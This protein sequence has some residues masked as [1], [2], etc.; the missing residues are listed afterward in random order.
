MASATGTDTGSAF[1]S[2]GA[3][4]HGIR[5]AFGTIPGARADGRG[6]CIGADAL[7]LAPLKG[8]AGDGY[9]IARSAGKITLHANTAVGVIGGLLALAEPAQAPDELLPRFKTR[10]YKHEIRF[11]SDEGPKKGGAASTVRPITRYTPAFVEAF[12]RELVRRHFNGLVLYAGYHP[13]E[14]FLDYEGFPHATYKPAEER[15]ENFRALKLLYGTA[16]KY[17][18]TTFLHHYVTHFTQA[19]SDHLNLSLKETGTRL[20]SF[21]H[22]RIYEYNRYIYRRT[23]ETLPELDGLYMNFESAAN[24]TAYMEK[25]LIPV[26]NA[27]ARKPVLFFRLWGISDVA[28]MKRLLAQYKGRKGL[29]HKIQENNDTYYYPVADDRVKVWKK[30]IPGIEFTFSVGPCHNCATNVG[31][32]LWT[33]LDYIHDLLASAQ[34]KGADSI[35]FQSTFELLLGHLPDAEFFPEHERNHARMNQGHLGAVVDY[36]RGQRPGPDAWTARYANWFRCSDKAASALR[37]AIVESSQIILK[38]YR[39]FCYGSPQEGHLYPGR[40]SH[41]QEPFFYYPMSF[42]NRL[43]EIPHNVAWKPWVVRTRPVKVVPNDTQAVIDFVN[44]SVRKKPANHPLALAK[45]IRAHGKAARK[46][47]ASYRK[48]A[49]EAADAAVIEQAERNLRNGERIER[50]IRIAVELYSCYFAPSARAFF[51]RLK[52]ARALMLETARVLGEHVRATDAYCSTT[53]SGPFQPAKDAEALAALLP[54]EGERVPFEALRHYLRSHERY[55]EIRRLCRPYVSV[56]PGEFMAKRNAGLLSE[57]LREAGRALEIL[58][59]EPWA[60]Y[61]ANVLAWRRY[62]QAELEWIVPPAMQAPEDAAVGPEQGFETMVHDQCYRW[63]QPCWEGFGSFFRRYDF[64]RE[65]RADC[66]ATRAEAGLKLTLRE[67][68][69]DWRAREET[70]AKNRG[71]INQT[72]FMRV[73][74]QT[75]RVAPGMLAYV[76]YFKGEGGTLQRP[77]E[78]PRLLEGCA[79][80]FEHTE[81]DWRFEIVIPWEQLGGKP[82]RG[83]RW[84]LNVLSNPAVLRNRQVA[85]CQ[86]YEFRDDAARLGTLQFV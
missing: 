10:N 28:G 82:K 77:G 17:G 55:N 53:S 6:L 46:A 64:F 36:V 86:A 44:P 72:G 8:H 65:D 54:Y 45:Q 79:V 25:T 23:F 76:I 59:P 78:K 37:T 31:S 50:E 74:L 42:H 49:G 40:W 38:Q 27:M 48:L 13:F 66:R 70:W 60:A 9:R 67:H 26:A 84:R 12:C 21:D 11:F 52:R 3:A 43:G 7:A 80:K 39:Q 22:P 73:F 68:G 5:W 83:E 29:I 35:S 1:E 20:A 63:G 57:A 33:V 58:A 41:Y 61:R 2:F 4:A 75:P 15:A 69:I 81:S 71:T 51:G 16:K 14:S 24:A 30:A 62:L 34:S 47:L 18:L 32:K 85:W 56:R 19:L